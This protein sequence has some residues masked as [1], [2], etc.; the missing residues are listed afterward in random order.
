MES[1]RIEIHWSTAP[2]ELR[3]AIDV[4]REVFCREQGVSLVEEV[5]GLDDEAEH[6]VALALDGRTVIGTLRLLV[7]GDSAKIGRVAVE[8]SWRR[9]GIAARMLELALAR[10]SSRG[11]KRARLAAQIDAVALYEQ[12][13]FDI[14]SDEFQEAGI[15]HVWMGRT[16]TPV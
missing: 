9:R 14:Q 7:D 8:R 6:L 10:A 4:R 2:A 11:C 1:E 15:A 5:D 12:A 16:L 3:G 13:G